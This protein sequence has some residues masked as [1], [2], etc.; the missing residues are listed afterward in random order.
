MKNYEDY[1][2][3]WFKDHTV[4]VENINDN[5]QII[6]WKNPESSMYYIKYIINNLTLI[7]IGDVGNAIYQWGEKINHKFLSLL[8]L[9]Y[10]ESKCVAS[11]TGRFAR[12]WDEDL[13]KYKIKEKIDYELEKEY[14]K[15]DIENQPDWKT[16]SKENP[17]SVIGLK[18]KWFD[19]AKLTYSDS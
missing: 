11:P 14:Y 16:Y 2:K 19:E 10:F 8:D 9:N 12:E 4:K 7:V 15:T 17:K 5:F 3:S 13:S 18:N 6:H 1:I